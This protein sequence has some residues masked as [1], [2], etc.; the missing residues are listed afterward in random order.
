MLKDAECVDFE[1]I[2]AIISGAVGRLEAV[3]TS[4]NSRAV[5]QAITTASPISV[6]EQVNPS[7][8]V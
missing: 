7:P 8:K 6:A 2:K 3:Y 4:R 5:H 1:S